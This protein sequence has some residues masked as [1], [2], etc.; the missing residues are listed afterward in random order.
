MLIRPNAKINLGL[1][2]VSRRPDGYH[3]LQTVFYPINLRDELEI[4]ARPDTTDITFTTTG[5]IALDCEDE[6]N[7]IVKTCRLFQRL[8]NTGGFDIRFKKNIP[9]GAGLGGGSSDAAHTAMAINELYHL[10]LS[11]EELKNAVSHLGADCA[12][13]IEN[14][15]CY[16]EG[17]GNI[18]TSVDISLKGYTLLLVKPDIHVSTKEAYRGITA[19]MPETGIK[20]IIRLP[21]EEWRD[22][23]CNDFEHSVFSAH[24]EIGTIKNRLYGMGAS[25]ASMSGSG[26]SVF[27]LFKREIHED[28]LSCLSD[29]FV[30]TESF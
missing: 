7:L 6:D 20:D 26:A 18:L 5:G 23:L 15:A 30:H 13:F 21:V 3:N 27:G 24:Q 4:D 2:I 8:Y 14:R 10:N 16:A 22:R 17:I 28:E 1:N 9:F 29:C 11:K 25:Y 19:R 12:F